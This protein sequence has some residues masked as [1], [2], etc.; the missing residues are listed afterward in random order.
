MPRRELQRVELVVLEQDIAA[1]LDLEALN[2][3]VLLNGLAAFSGDLLIPDAL[4]ALAINLMKRDFVF[5]R[6]RA[7][8]PDGNG[9]EG[10]TQMAFPKRTHGRSH[11]VTHYSR[12]CELNHKVALGSLVP[13]QFVI[14]STR[15]RT[16]S[17]LASCERPV[18][19]EPMFAL[20]RSM[21]MMD[22]LDY[23]LLNATSSQDDDSLSFQRVL[24]DLSSRVICVLP[25]K[26]TI[27]TAQRMKIIPKHFLACY[28]LPSAIVSSEPAL[29]AQAVEVLVDDALCLLDQLSIPAGT[30][31]SV[32]FS[33]GNGP[34]T[35]LANKAHARLCSVTSADRG[36]L[37][38]WQ[39]DAA[40]DVKHLARRKGYQSGDFRQ[41]LSGLDPIDNLS[42]IAPDSV[43]IAAERDMFVPKA[44]RMA[45]LDAVRDIVPSAQIMTADRGHVRT[46]WQT[47]QRLPEILGQSVR[48]GIG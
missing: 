38:L 27:K 32:G 13:V 5:R 44:R 3:I 1:R 19:P 24:G 45:L 4:L 36:D 35:V 20:L 47:A 17:Q 22:A 15:G 33:M 30:V 14:V 6:C 37:M 39:S 23:V 28:Q 26:V 2:D 16:N 21:P 25:W 31:T 18:L 10:Q 29:C 11:G 43:F 48:A 8:E 46:I 9:D 40:V 41:A 7:H 12:V 42:N 34:A